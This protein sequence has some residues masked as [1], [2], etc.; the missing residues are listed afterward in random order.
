M[1]EQVMYILVKGYN[2]WTSSISYTYHVHSYTISNPTRS[3][4]SNVV[5]EIVVGKSCLWVGQRKVSV[6]KLD[7]RK[8][9]NNRYKQLA[10]SHGY[11]D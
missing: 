9:G 3:S 2:N 11:T 5:K 4:C 8:E 7:D 10:Q 1:K 6:S